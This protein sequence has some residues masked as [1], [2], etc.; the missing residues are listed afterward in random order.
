ME[1]LRQRQW[2]RYTT[3][4]WLAKLI[5]DKNSSDNKI[6]EDCVKFLSTKEQYYHILYYYNNKK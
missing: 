3:E 4:H 1:S 6:S 5:S 2:N